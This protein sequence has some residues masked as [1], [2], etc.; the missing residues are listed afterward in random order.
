MEPTTA[1]PKFAILCQRTHQQQEETKKKNPQKPF[2]E[3]V[4]KYI[5]LELSH[6]A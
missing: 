4:P 1:F 3:M 5:D 6:V 2:S